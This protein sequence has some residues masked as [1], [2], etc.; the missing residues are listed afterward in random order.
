MPPGSEPGSSHWRA[1]SGPRKL[2]DG[3]V[4]AWMIAATGTVLILFSAFCFVAAVWRQAFT[5]APPPDPD[6]RRLPNLILVVVNGFLALVAIVA[7]VG[8]LFGRTTGS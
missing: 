2:L 1:A 6:V 7:L 8:V 5:G 4:P 3:T